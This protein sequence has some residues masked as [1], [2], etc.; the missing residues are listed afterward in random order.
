MLV[1]RLLVEAQER[2]RIG[3]RPV[4]DTHEAAAR[5][6]SLRSRRLAAETDL[7]LKRVALSDL[8][9]LRT[10]D[11]PLHL[12]LAA[13]RSDDVGALADW[14]AQVSERNPG[15]R[16]AEARLRAAE[17]EQRK[18]STALSPSLDLVAQIGRERLSG[19]G[20]FGGASNTSSNRAVG[21]QLSVP[22]YTG[23]WRGARQ[24]E[25]RARVAKAQADLER[26][27]QQV[28]L[29]TR[30][31]WLDLAVGSGQESAL[32]AAAVAS[33]ARLDATRVGRRA[34]DRTTQE[35]LDAENDAA[36]AEL[37]L[38]EAR[39]RLLTN[40]LRLFALGGQL[41]DTHLSR[42]DAALLAGQ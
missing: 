21:V 39:V 7:E 38:I 10:V 18:T 15:L 1:A 9:G 32:A 2:F 26:A 36:A 14:L 4:I 34:G 13:P 5:A 31:V 35:L 29:Q 12:P 28:A 24:T 16:V 3:D 27:R 33:L 22:L 37:A 25:A 6:A 30:S 23:G 17:Q 20:D 11:T 42:L 8:T 41:E 19:S 40:R